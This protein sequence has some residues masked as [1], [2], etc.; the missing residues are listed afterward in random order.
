MHIYDTIIIGAGPAGLTAGIYT[1]RRTL[2][3]LI[4]GAEIGGQ[5]AKTFVIENYPGLKS[6]DGFAL[7]NQMLEQVKEL[8][9]EF[10]NDTTVKISKENNLFSVQTA[11]NKN[12]TAKTIIIT[13]GLKKRKLGLE[14]EEKF[15]GH[16]LSYCINCDGPLFKNKN[17]AVVGGGNSGAEA[18]EFLAKICPTVYWLEIT[19]TLR[20][21]PILIE[22]LKKIPAVNILTN[23]QIMAL[24]GNE[25]LTAIKIKTNNQE[26]NLEVEGVF[27]EIGYLAETTWLKDFINLDPLGQVIIDEL[28]HTN[29]PGVFAAGDVSNSKYKQVIVAAGTGAIAALEAYE[30]IQKNS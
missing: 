28:N 7:A 1:T 10:I 15:D 16:G 21:D 26:N 11:A 14:G 17:V 3:T 22:R 4:I 12:Y 8:G 20:A 18:V 6:I 30:Y 24:Q 23:T 29:V 13:S 27:V 25:K 9:A 19:D 5:M 2:K